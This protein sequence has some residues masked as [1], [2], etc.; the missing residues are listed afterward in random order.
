[1]KMGKVC[2]L[3]T[4]VCI[5]LIGCGKGTGQSLGDENEW[6]PGQ[7]DI[8]NHVGSEQLMDQAFSE[9]IANNLFN[10]SSLYDTEDYQS[11]TGKWF[12]INGS[13][14]FGYG[15]TGGTKKAGDELFVSLIPHDS[16][17][18]QLKRDV[19]IQL[20]MFSPEEEETVIDEV[21]YVDTVYSDNPI[22]ENTL[23][24]EENVYYIVSA[25]IMDSQ[26]KVEDTLLSMIYVPKEELNASLTIEKEVYDSNEKEA[27]LTLKNYG[28]SILFL[29]KHFT[30]EKKV[31]DTWRIVPLDLAFEDIGL[32][33]SLGK[34]FEQK[35]DISKLNEG[36]YR[37]VKEI[38]VEGMELTKTL[39]AE[40]TK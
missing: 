34:E 17:G 11:Q 22:Y 35:V 3:F 2:L 12:L 13:G 15:I 30:I 6:E 31:G 7:G 10:Y 24:E 4:F 25:E 21:V 27:K 37:V 14:V 36:E 39:A 40:F 32:Y 19:R 20:K 38:R 1:M 23:P 28:P 9:K 5:F 8:P 26:G 18:V 33:V 16:K 29:G